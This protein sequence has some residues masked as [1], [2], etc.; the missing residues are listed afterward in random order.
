MREVF[1]IPVV[2]DPFA[3]V[4]GKVANIANLDRIGLG[5]SRN[6]FCFGIAVNGNAKPILRLW[7]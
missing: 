7:S 6:L 2:M 5:M 3:Q 1:E 4:V